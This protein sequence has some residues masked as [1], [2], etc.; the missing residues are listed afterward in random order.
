MMALIVVP[1][2]CVILWGPILCRLW[3]WFRDNHA[4]ARIHAETRTFVREMERRTSYRTLAWKRCERERARE[5]RQRY[6]RE[7]ARLKPGD[8]I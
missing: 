5:L 7:R 3:L 8:R 2:C 4:T 1:A 6:A